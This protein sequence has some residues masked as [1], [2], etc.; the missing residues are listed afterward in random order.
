MTNYPRALTSLG[1]IEAVPRRIRARLAGRIILDTTDALY[2]WDIPYYPQYYIPINDFDQEFLSM[3]PAASRT[4]ASWQ[5]GFVFD[6]QER[7][8]ALTVHASLSSLHPGTYAKVEWDAVDAWFEEDEEVFVHPRN[9]YQRVDAVRSHRHLTVAIDGIELAETVSPVM[10]FETSL[11]TRYY[12]DPTDVHWSNLA[13]T[14]TQTACPYK[15]VTTGY[16]SIT[17]DLGTYEDIA[18]AYNYPKAPLQPIAGLVAF[19][20]EKV[21]ITL[22]GKSIERPVTHF[23]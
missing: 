18:W 19:Y 21:D 6:G 8:G 1:H 22:D 7:S 12:I 9:P 15:G 4:D 11:P 16:W 10:V 3:P 17:T 20:N 13:P 14:T 23:S 5:Q 2:R